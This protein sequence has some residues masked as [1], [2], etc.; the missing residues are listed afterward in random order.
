MLIIIT[1]Q[2]ALVKPAVPAAKIKPPPGEHSSGGGL[3]FY[4]EEER[5]SVSGPYQ[6]RGNAMALQMTL[7]AQ[8]RMAGTIDCLNTLLMS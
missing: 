7:T 2:P 8:K 5:E 1:R 3:C 6:Y 4:D